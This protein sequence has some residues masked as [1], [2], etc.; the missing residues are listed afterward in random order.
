VDCVIRKKIGCTSGH[1]RLLEGKTEG[2][3]SRFHLR[4]P[5]RG[6]TDEAYSALDLEETTVVNKDI[7]AQLEAIFAA[8]KDKEVRAQATA[9]DAAALQQAFNQRFDECSRTVIG[10]ALQEIA[11]RLNERGIVAG[12]AVI[13]GAIAIRVRGPGDQRL[14]HGAATDLSDEPYLVIKAIPA[15]QSVRFERNVSGRGPSAGVGEHKVEEITVDLV[16]KK[17]LALVREIHG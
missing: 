15:T 11:E 5:R 2:R 8:R 13:D 4:Q 1:A 16:Q 7:E 17:V 10:P 12:P 14:Y 9:T 6:D 3:D